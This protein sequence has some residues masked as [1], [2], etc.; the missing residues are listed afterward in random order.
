M[1]PTVVG[2]GWAR[3]PAVLDGGA[4]VR[5][6]FFQ[7]ILRFLLLPLL[8]YPILNPKS[9]NASP[10]LLDLKKTKGKKERKKNYLWIGLK[11]CAMPLLLLFEFAKAGVGDF[12]ACDWSVMPPVGISW[13]VVLCWFLG[14]FGF[15]DCI[16]VCVC[17]K[18]GVSLCD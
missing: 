8:L 7:K 10:E 16:T 15:C 2:D 11:R 13:P 18:L 17:L 1:E 9:P 3:W 12:A 6:S 4:A 5:N 14:Q